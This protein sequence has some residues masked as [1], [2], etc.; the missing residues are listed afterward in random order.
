MVRI[1]ADLART[2]PPGVLGLVAETLV[3]LHRGQGADIQW[4]ETAYVPSLVEYMSMIAGKTGALLEL[5]PRL[6][7]MY[8]TTDAHDRRWSTLFQRLGIY[9]QIRDDFCNICDPVYWAAKGFFEDLDEGK[10]SYVVLLCLHQRRRGYDRLREIL[11][12]RPDPSLKREAYSILLE[13]GAL[14]ETHEYLWQTYQQLML[15]GGETFRA[16]LSSLSI[17]D[18]PEVGLLPTILPACRST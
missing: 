13:S 3:R 5:I 4:S 9:F 7:A 11:R 12:S 6:A 8:G 10:M 15:Q 2:G 16:V 1:L 17:P 18:I 14:H